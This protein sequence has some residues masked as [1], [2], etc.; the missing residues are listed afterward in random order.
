MRS[1]ILLYDAYISLNLFDQDLPRNL[2]VGRGAK[3]AC[4]VYGLKWNEG[5]GILNE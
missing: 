3:P 2:R 5:V 4:K 1:F